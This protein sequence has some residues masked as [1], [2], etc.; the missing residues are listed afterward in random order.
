VL[1]VIAHK[2]VQREAVMSSD[3]VDAG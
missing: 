3:E 2:V 1:A